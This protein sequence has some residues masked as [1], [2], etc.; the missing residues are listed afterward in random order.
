MASKSLDG[1]R[2][3]GE[4]GERRKSKERKVVHG[5][6]ESRASYSHLTVNQ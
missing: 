6:S 4:R 2:Q 1:C 5:E 3:P